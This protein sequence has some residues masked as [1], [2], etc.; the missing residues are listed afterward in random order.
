MSDAASAQRPSLRL[1]YGLAAAT[2]AGAGLRAAAPVLVPVALALFLAILCQPLFVGMLRRRVPLGFAVLITLL[3]LGLA[4]A[5][6]LVLLLGSIAEVREVGPHYW[7]GLR[8][9][10][11]YTAEWWQQKGIMISDWVPARFREPEALLNLAG[12]T[13]A[14]ALRLLSEG[15]IVLL[16]LFFLLFEVALAPRRIATLPPAVRDRFAH[17]AN[18]SAELQRYLAIKTL[19]AAAIGLAAGLWVA[20]L[21]VDF[22]VL[23]GLLAFGFHF[24]PNVGALF[25]AVPAMVIAFAEFDAAKALAVGAGYLVLGLVLGSL[26]EPALMGRRLNLS[27]LAVF[28]SLVIWG[29]LWGPIGMFLSVPMTMAIKIVLSHSP[30]WAWTARLLDGVRAV[31]EATAARTEEE[32]APAS[33]PEPPAAPAGAGPR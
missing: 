5:L 24:V 33:G 16:T 28:L 9:R 13:L 7:A 1:L 30:D 18:V 20:G 22:P 10:I 29:W 17:F 19:M 14:G 11:A 3:V 32:R 6:F 4:I 2:I 15:T 26:V 27:P 8:E 31:G 12:G 25:A 21:G 23:C